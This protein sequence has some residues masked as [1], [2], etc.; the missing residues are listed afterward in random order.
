MN[1]WDMGKYV[2]EIASCYSRDVPGLLQGYSR[3]AYW[4]VSGQ[5]HLV[6]LCAGHKIIGMGVERASQ[7]YDDL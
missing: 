7:R 4:A 3:A 2:F 1:T 5:L 6:G